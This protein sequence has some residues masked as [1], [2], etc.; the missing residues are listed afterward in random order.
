MPALTTRKVVRLGLMIT[1]DPQEKWRIIFYCK[2]KKLILM[3]M[4]SYALLLLISAT[5]LFSCSKSDTSN[6]SATSTKP[7][8]SD[9]VK[10]RTLPTYCGTQGIPGSTVGSWYQF[11]LVA[12]QNINAGV[13]TIGQAN[14][15]WQVSID[16][17]GDWYVTEAH[18]KFWA[19][20]A[21][22]TAPASDLGNPSPGQF[23]VH[24]YGSNPISTKY[25]DIAIPT[26]VYPWC[27]PQCINIAVHAVVKRKGANGKVAQEETAWAGCPGTPW[28]TQGNWGLYLWCLCFNPC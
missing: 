18:V 20:P 7:D 23:P 5:T 2:P 25:V 14:G 27:P 15:K 26:S 11:T 13:V 17:Y 1:F 16:T 21:G 3:K 10:L 8:F 24:W 12:G 9:D 19:V 22:Q 4:K 6:L 28:N